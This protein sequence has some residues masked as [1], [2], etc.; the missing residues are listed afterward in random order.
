MKRHA[1]LTAALIAAALIA[2]AS[3]CAAIITPQATEH[4]YAA[5]DGA[6]AAIGDLKIRGVMVITKGKGKPGQL[7]A[8]VFN[9]SQSPKTAKISTP[10]FSTTVRVKPESE[11]RLDPKDGKNVVIP[12]VSTKP[13]EL[14]KVTLQSGSKSKRFSSQ[15]FNGALPQYKKYL[16]SPKPSKSQNKSQNKS[17]P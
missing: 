17:Q 11:V 7:L 6:A 10:S 3:G 5:G 8:T 9:S 15:V 13:G 12:S 2:P 1:R 14:L 16:P 4:K